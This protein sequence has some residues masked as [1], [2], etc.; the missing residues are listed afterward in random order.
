MSRGDATEIALWTIGTYQASGTRRRCEVV[1]D[2]T[3]HGLIDPF[4]GFTHDGPRASLR[5]QPSRQRSNAGLDTPA[6]RSMHATGR[7]RIDA[8]QAGSRIRTSGGFDAA[9]ADSG[10]HSAVRWHSHERAHLLEIFRFEFKS[11]LV[12]VSL[13]V[14]P[15]H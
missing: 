10:D 7:S 1:S 4:P 8:G 5:T 9:A 6:T 2:G 14:Y 11:K 12:R 3:T 13:T 15:H